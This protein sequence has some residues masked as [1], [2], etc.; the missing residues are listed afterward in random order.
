[1]AYPT[2]ALATEV[3]DAADGYIDAYKVVVADILD[4]EQTNARVAALL[5]TLSASMD[6]DIAVLATVTNA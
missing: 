6:A 3:A 4:S 1:M 5:T 2:G